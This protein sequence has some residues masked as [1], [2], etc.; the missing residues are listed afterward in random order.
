LWTSQRNDEL[1]AI[2]R[3]G[4]PDITDEGIREVLGT[5][6]T[7]LVRDCLEKKP[8]E[9]DQCIFFLGTIA[10]SADIVAAQKQ[11][12]WYLWYRANQRE[13]DAV[14]RLSVPAPAPMER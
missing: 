4:N 8:L 2:V 11:V 1:V 5:L 9:I 6:G 14:R 10:D 13:L 7:E 3:R 12:G